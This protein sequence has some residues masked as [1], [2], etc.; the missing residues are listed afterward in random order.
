MFAPFLFHQV[1]SPSPQKPVSVSS[2]PPEQAS[3]DGR[4]RRLWKVQDEW[5][6]YKKMK[7]ATEV[8]KAKISE[9]TFKEDLSLLRL[10]T[11]VEES[12]RDFGDLL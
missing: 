11:A 6:D 12:L 9:N 2:A 4:T 1:K 3:S 8:A 7:R 10:A 5:V